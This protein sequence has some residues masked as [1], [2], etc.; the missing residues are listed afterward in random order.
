MIQRELNMSTHILE[1]LSRM[2]LLK[3]KIESFKKWLESCYTQ[4]IHPCNFGLKRLD[5][6]CYI[7]NSFLGHE[8]SRPLINYGLGENLTLSTLG[9]LAMSVTY[10]GME[11]T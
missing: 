7:A 4:T 5:I 9:H 6:A 2:K 10:S 11:K 1:L 8:Q 3:G